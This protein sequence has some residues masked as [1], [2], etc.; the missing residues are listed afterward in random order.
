MKSEDIVRDLNKLKNKE[1]AKNSS[2]FFKTKEGQ[3]GYGDKFLGISVPE[4]RKIAKKYIKISLSEIQK[5]LKSPIHEHRFTALEILVMKYENAEINEKEK[6]V[7]F[8]LKNAKSINNWDLVDTSASY[9]LGN[10]LYKKDRGVL[11]GLVKS[12]NLWE[13]RIAVVSTHFFIQRGDFKDIIR[14]SKILLKDKHDLIQ[15]AVGWM[16]REAGKVNE[17]ILLYFL[18]KY[19]K[20]MSRTTLR[21]SLERLSSTQKKF[22]MQK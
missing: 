12:E 4:Q 18:D 2:G 11:Y 21:Y 8:Y 15:K 20:E 5:L 13:R 6:I 10:F 16:L 14:L 22:Y 9:I 17:K 3:Y 7:K 1:K 19:H